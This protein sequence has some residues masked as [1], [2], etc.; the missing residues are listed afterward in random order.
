MNNDSD[1]TRSIAALG[2]AVASLEG[3]LAQVDA[4]VR[5]ARAARSDYVSG[6][7]GNLLPAISG[8][9]LERLR[10]AQ[11]Q[12]V[13][14]SVE[15]AFAQKRKILGLFAPSGYDAALTTLQTRL[16][17]HLERAG[18]ASLPEFDR[19]LREL[20]QERVGLD[21]QLS[22][23]RATLNVL[24]RA[25]QRATVLPQD[26]HA[27]LAEVAGNA[28]PLGRAQGDSAIEAAMWMAFINEVPPTLRPTVQAALDR[29]DGDD[30]SDGDASSF[31]S[32][33]DSATDDR[34]GAFS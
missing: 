26:A 8:G 1:L 33:D 5:D 16:A 24:R 28:R 17:H 30:D 9:V 11:P 2:Q 32:D 6:Q 34:L 22:E 15:Q 29:D 25:W 23:A 4:H 27:Q 20:E 31:T 13:D 10:A 3:R 18:D 14:A 12:F 7:V 21:G 19:R